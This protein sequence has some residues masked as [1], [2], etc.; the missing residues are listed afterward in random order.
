MSFDLGPARSAAPEEARRYGLLDHPVWAALL[1]LL[2][3]NLAV[4]LASL[5]RGPAGSGAVILLSLLL[6]YLFKRRFRPLY[7]GSLA[8]RGLAS[9][10]LWGL[11]AAA[12]LLPALAAVVRHGPALPLPDAVLRA[13]AAALSEE[14]IFRGLIAPNWLRLRRSRRHILWNVL[15]TAAVF[16][17]FHLANAASGAAT[18]ATV[19]QAVCAIGAGVFFGA[20]FLRSGSLWPAVLAHLLI[21]LC[22]FLAGE[23]AR[24]MDLW[25][26]G[27]AIVMAAWGL[28]LIRPS[29]REAILALWDRKWSRSAA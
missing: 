2:I 19:W 22:A 20:V 29:R 11:P 8:G 26:L 23:T 5:L 16:G 18:A 7:E 12:A 24:A 1:A 9:G 3:G 4:G 10:L 14:T 17:L 6:L 28:Y 13:A 21:D 25:S 15:V 27:A